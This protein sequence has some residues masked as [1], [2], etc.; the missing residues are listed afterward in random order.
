MPTFSRLCFHASCL[1]A[2]AVAVAASPLAG[3]WKIDTARSTELSPWRTYQLD[4]TV[5]GDRVVIAR[6]L[7]WG[8]RTHRESMT[9]DTSSDVNAVPLD[10]WV[11]NRH[12]G[13][14][15]GGDRQQQVRATW[16][17]DRRV[18]RLDADLTLETQ[19]GERD[20]NILS[21]YHASP[22]G[23]TLTL[24]QMRS[25]RPRPVVYVFTKQDS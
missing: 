19:Q 8:R 12:L 6:Q 22:D 7:G 17:D 15:L 24:T 23:R 11:D 16:V 5:D 18:L 25:T 10:Y 3:S 13:A 1:I 9:L 14:Y 4:I 20:V 21:Q 2:T